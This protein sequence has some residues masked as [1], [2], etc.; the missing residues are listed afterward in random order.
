MNMNVNMNTCRIFTARVWLTECTSP[1]LSRLVAKSLI[2]KYKSQRRAGVYRIEC[3][4]GAKFWV[5]SRG[6]SRLVTSLL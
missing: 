4:S 2:L 5:D 1:Y 3:H 6:I